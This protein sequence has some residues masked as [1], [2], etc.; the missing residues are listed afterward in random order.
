ML[1]NKKGFTLVELLIVVAI[2]AVLAAIAVP[3]VAGL[4]D[5]SNVSADKSN[6]AEMTN[7]IE[8]FA[9]EYELVKQDLYSGNF[10]I[11]NADSSQGRVQ[12]AIGLSSK[13][14]IYN[15]ETDRLDAS[16]IAIN[17]D[18]KYPINE[19]T[20]KSIIEKYLKASSAVFTP[21]QSDCSYY[22]SPELGKVVVAPT[23][24]TKTELMDI[25]F[26]ESGNPQ[27]VEWINL[28]I[29]ANIPEGD[30]SPDVYATDNKD[31]Y[32]NLITIVDTRPVTPDTCKH[33]STSTRGA[34]S[35]S[36]AQS[37]YT[38]DI[39]CNTCSAIIRSGSTISKLPH[40][41]TTTGVVAATCTTDGYTGDSS[42]STCHLV[43]SVGQ[44]IPATGHTEKS[45]G[46]VAA[47]CTTDGFTGNKV[48]STCGAVIQSGSPITA[49]GHQNT[50]LRNVSAIY[51]GDVWCLDCKTIVETGLSISHSGGIIPEGGIY[52]TGRF[53]C[54]ECGYL[55]TEPSPYG[56]V[57]DE[58]GE[59][60]DEGWTW[61]DCGS[62]R[63]PLAEDWI[64]CAVY[65]GGDAF[66]TLRLN[67]TYEYEDYIY[68]Y[69][70]SYWKAAVK[71]NT[72]TSYS[73]LIP[74]INN[75][76]MAS[77]Y[78]TFRNC[79][80]LTAHG[81]PE[82]P[83]TVTDMYF[84]FADNTQFVDLTNV[85]LPSSVTYLYGTFSNCTSLKYVPVLSNNVQNI[86]YTYQGTAITTETVPTIPNSV[87][88]MDGTFKS[89]QGITS[90][91]NI[92]IPSGVK[93]LSTTFAYTSIGNDGFPTFPSSI[94]KMFS[95]F[96]NC[97][98]ITSLANFRGPSNVKEVYQVFSH[99]YNLAS[100]DGFVLPES[101]TYIR[102][103][104]NYC[105]GLSDVDGFVI[106][107][108]V[109]NVEQAFRNCRAGL[110]GTIY[111][112]STPTAYSGMFMETNISQLTIAG[113]CNTA[114]KQAIAK[115]G[116]NS[117]ATVK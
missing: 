96:S 20:V 111:I 54:Y 64:E 4:I 105:Y 109:T 42:C 99:C 59:W 108:N 29:N 58:Y 45:E 41:N 38:G 15:I 79:P 39:V 50:E 12:S 63:A 43:T 56:D 110:K 13:Q 55:F 91:K 82:I 44:T 2:L 51:S 40:N 73:A 90:A 35:A 28:S 6:A 34:T 66:P 9:S 33:T 25:A 47:T 60:I 83:N 85:V 10:S 86:G 71:D 23:G 117:T 116:S 69:T 36:C 106:P 100:L 17:R 65:E 26:A 75:A 1:G 114:T 67:D 102:A 89:C 94:E 74:T 61:C 101:T 37:G 11:T 21:K 52:T 93:S 16:T 72:Q 107:K 32:T 112:N 5:R 19:K 8:R 68:T 49:T 18:T 7:A 76:D 81:I 103:I 104:F 57:F 95:T 97:Q 77:L 30:W 92:N 80:N 48:C 70:G 24:A 115:T 31:S 88:M 62:E 22:Y 84:A 27:L 98:N 78:E 53:T 113:N 87:T 3:M 46:Y 14:D